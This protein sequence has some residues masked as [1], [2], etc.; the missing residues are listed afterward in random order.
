MHQRGYFARMLTRVFVAGLIVLIV[1]CGSSGPAKVAPTTTVAPTPTVAL[2]T[3]TTIKLGQRS[4]N[5]LIK[6]CDI[7]TKYIKGSQIVLDLYGPPLDFDVIETLVCARKSMSAGGKAV[8][9][10]A[11]ALS[12][13]VTLSENGLKY[14]AIYSAVT[15][16]MKNVLVVDIED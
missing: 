15:G 13:P 1:G 12:G 2:A 14:T 6:R 4:F 3:T 9:E 10:T 7:P 8:L 16:R 5:S 11:T